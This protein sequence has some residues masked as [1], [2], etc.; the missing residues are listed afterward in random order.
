MQKSGSTGTQTLERGLSVIAAVADGADDLS[1]ISLAIGLSRSTTQRLAAMLVRERMLRIEAGAYLLGP[2]LI[3]LGFRAREQIPLTALARP[4]L[5]TLA[6]KTQDSVHLVLPEGHEV[7]YIDKI[8][9]RRGYELRS[10]IGSRMPMA[11]TGVGK[12]LMLDMS[13]EKWQAL[14]DDAVTGTETVTVSGGRPLPWKDFCAAMSRYA[15]RGYAFDLA[16]NEFGVRCVSAPIRDAGGHIIAAVS[17]AAAE[18]WMDDDRME[19]VAPL[20]LECA[21]AVSLGIGWHG[22]TNAGLSTYA[23]TKEPSK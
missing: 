7:L 1:K 6:S 5:E 11:L 18:P 8:P 20:V 21:L 2:K 9:G 12:A 16:E 3:E 23:G 10:R 15:R 17:V 14:Y 22:D 19:A 13:P 4:H